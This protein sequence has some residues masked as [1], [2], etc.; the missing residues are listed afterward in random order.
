MGMDARRV[1]KLNVL[2][3]TILVFLMTGCTSFKQNMMVDT[4]KLMGKH[5][6][7]VVN[8]YPDPEQ[9]RAAMPVMIIQSDM[10]LEMG[11]NDPQLL[12]SASELNGG[13]AMFLQESDKKRSAKYYKKAKDYAL[14]V[15]KQNS[16]FN[17]ALGKSDEEYAKA[18][19]TFQKEDVPALF[20]LLTSTFGWISTSASDNP[21]AL[22]DL[23]KAEAIMD[24]ILVL[25][26]TF[27]YGGV[28]AVLG[29]YNAARPV[30]FGGNPEKAKFHYDEAF[31]I[32]DRKF[33]MW[34][35][36]YAKY[37]A[38]RIQDRELFVK[39]LEEVISAPDNLIPEQNLANEI[40]R[41][42]A[43]DLLAQVDDQF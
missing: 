35:V 32:S 3:G 39:T 40:A 14:R 21:A 34:L 2:L 5:G 22:L 42:K 25:D 36:F 11:P 38:F 24:R 41:A 33:L 6:K 29:T 30:M 23:P 20:A 7:R 43:K 19:L 31:K 13:Y 16:I 4:A 15:L 26:D 12:L 27:K 18:L 1:A 28:H 10:F 17:E 8:R 9:M 37:Y